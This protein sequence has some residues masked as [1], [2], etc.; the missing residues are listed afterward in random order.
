MSESSESRWDNSTYQ[1]LETGQLY[2]RTLVPYL[3][4][5]CKEAIS[6]RSQ[7]KERHKA[8]FPNKE[9]RMLQQKYLKP[10][11]WPEQAIG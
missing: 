11:W 6:E 9:V 2:P 5:P 10:L 3:D 7:I 8:K 1:D 4:N